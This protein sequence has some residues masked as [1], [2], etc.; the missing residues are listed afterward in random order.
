MR[1]DVEVDNRIFET[2]KFVSKLL[3]AGIIFQF[4]LYVNPG[5]YQIQAAFTSMLAALLSIAGLDLTYSGIRIFTSEATYI[6]V[7]DCLGW[8]SMA[9]FIALIWASTNR[10]LEHLNFILIGLAV[11]IVG[12]IVRV[13][14]T[15]Y[16]AEIGLISFDII[17]D[18]L[19]RWS[20]TLMV[21]G[22]WGY[23]LKN[24][25]EE[26]RFDKKIRRQIRSL[27]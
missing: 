21:L 14:S 25:K 5:T 18:T 6:I 15:V 2:F 16:F 17:H 1:F 27:N 12:N 10:T 24:W 19:W 11:L 4:I 23:W 9:A 13:F 26:Q 8:K 3:I 7:Q 22:M 20:L